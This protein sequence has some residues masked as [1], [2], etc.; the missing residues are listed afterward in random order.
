M[1]RT[2]NKPRAGER[3]DGKTRIMYLRLMVDVA[4]ALRAITMKR[5]DLPKVLVSMLEDTDL[6]NVPLLDIT[7]ED[8]VET[9][10]WIISKGNYNKLHRAAAQRGCSVNALVNS[11]IANK[12]T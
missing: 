2:G 6:E 7:F 4:T 3:S 5:G 10:L 8:G 12:T 1:P 9:T 11:M